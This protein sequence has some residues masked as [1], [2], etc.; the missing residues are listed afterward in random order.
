MSRVLYTQEALEDLQTIKARIIDNFCDEELAV[1]SLRK[2]MQQ[3]QGIAEFPHMG[4]ELEKIIGIHSDYY[5]LFRKSNYIFYRIENDSIKIIRILNERQ[6]Y[7][8]ILFGISETE[9]FNE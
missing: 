8:R 6:D 3:I 5:Y 2:L 4:M 1:K 9:E 7:I